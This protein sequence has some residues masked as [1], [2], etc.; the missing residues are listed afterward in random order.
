MTKWQHGAKLSSSISILS[1]PA[2]PLLFCH[3]VMLS[4]AILSF[5]RFV[6][7]SFLPFVM[8]S[9]RHS[10]ILPFRHVAIL[11]FCHVVVSPVCHFCNRHVGIS[12]FCHFAIPSYCHSAIWVSICLHPNSFQDLQMTSKFGPDFAQ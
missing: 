6:I 1:R 5:R 8:S 9:F 11:S 7:L 10:V 2:S 4:F 3:S 12:S